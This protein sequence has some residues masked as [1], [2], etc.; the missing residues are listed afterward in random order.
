MAVFERCKTGFAL[1]GQH[2]YRE[3]TKALQEVVSL[4]PRLYLPR[5]C[6]AEIAVHESRPADA[7]RQLQTALS[8]LAA[9]K[10]VLTPS[11]GETKTT[12]ARQCHRLLGRALLMDGKPDQAADEIQSALSTDPDSFSIEEQLKLIDLLAARGRFSDAVADCRKVLKTDPQ[13]AVARNRLAWMLATCPD[14]SIRDGAKALEVARLLVQGSRQP[15]F[16]DTLAAAYAETGQFPKA[17]ATAEE[18]LALA[19][20]SGRRID[21][22]SIQTHLRLYRVGRPYRET[23]ESAGP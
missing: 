21:A 22:L 8:I 4:R 15:A 14:A 11:S 1:T 7:I 23:P 5:Y 2:H 3:A 13:N 10:N 12:R 18:A 9:S 17:V 20:S 6:L 19:K 16:L